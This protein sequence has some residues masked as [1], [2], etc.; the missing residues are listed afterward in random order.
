MLKICVGFGERYRS[1]EEKLR[2][3]VKIN[4]FKISFENV[5]KCKKWNLGKCLAKLPSILYPPPPFFY[6]LFFGGGGD[7]II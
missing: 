5:K 1:Q 4:V 2:G 3:K 6:F 7:K